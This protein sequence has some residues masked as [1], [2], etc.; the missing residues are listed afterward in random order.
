MIYIGIDLEMIYFNII[1]LKYEFNTVIYLK[2][3]TML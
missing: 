3:I 1:T 2:Y